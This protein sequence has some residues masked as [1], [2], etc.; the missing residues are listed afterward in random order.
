MNDQ[1]K[2]DGTNEPADL[3]IDSTI[4]KLAEQYASCERRSKAINDER[5]L[6][7]DNAEKLGIP[8]L[9]FQHGVRMVKLMTKGER[10]DYSAG[11]KRVVAVI[12][13]RQ[14]ELFPDDAERQR[15][16][17]EKA[18]AEAAKQ[19]RSQEELDAETNKN[20]RSDPKA[21]GAGK[22]KKGAKDNVVPL[23]GPAEAVADGAKAGD[24]FLAEQIAKNQQAEQQEGEKALDEATKQSQSAQAAAKRVEAGLPA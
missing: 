7:R 23:K 2:F 8:S 3:H 21:G 17:E 22:G 1:P 5:K 16:R 18:A 4:I 20:K 14:A 24:A 19:P 15:K 9:S 13:E 11:L 12:G 10:A 6:I